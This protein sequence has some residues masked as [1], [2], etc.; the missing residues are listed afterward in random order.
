MSGRAKFPRHLLDRPW[1]ERLGY[2]H[3]C[4]VPHARMETVLAEIKSA[5][6]RRA[7]E[8]FIF[9]VGPTRIGKTTVFEYL[10]NGLLVEAMD[11]M[12]SDPG[13]LPVAG[14]EAWN[15][16]R[17]Y[18][19]K[20]HWAGCLEALNEPLIGYKTDYG[21]SDVELG[22]NSRAHVRESRTAAILRRAFEKAARERKLRVFCIDEAH[23]LT[24][25]PLARLHRAQIEI[26]KSVASKSGAMHVLFGTYDLLKLRNA[27]GQ[28]GSR[29][30]TVHFNR[31][32]P[33]SKGDLT[34]FADAALSL[35]GHMPLAETPDLKKDMDYC[36]DVS[37][38]L[39]GLLKV[40]FTDALGAA[41]EE[42]RNT[43]TRKDLEKHEPPL[44]VLEKI[45]SE[46]VIGEQMLEQDEGR[47]S[48]IRLRMLRGSK[49]KQ[50][51]PSPEPTNPRQ[52]SPAEEAKGADDSD[53]PATS[54]QPKRQARK[55]RRIER[56]PKRDSVGGGGKKN[57]A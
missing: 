51:A 25:V 48:L 38:G 50:P 27:N 56:S 21:D 17:G 7:Y 28:L 45:S 44:D 18:D 30:V 19:W 13:C 29:A 12:K 11:N 10:I 4:R 16:P 15:Y 22:R 43:L 33:V 5:I 46:I 41:L 32:R 35:V 42:G 26:I 3:S 39:I 14:M 37:L 54:P 9:V 23:H 49:F 8:G 24:L 31:Y 20:D 52:D 1:E 2:F 57:V 36:F 53:A 55:G 40:W 6:R 47:R 34:G